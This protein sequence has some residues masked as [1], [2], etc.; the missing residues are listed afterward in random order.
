MRSGLSRTVSQLV[1]RIGVP[2]LLLALGLGTYA[3]WLASRDHT[4][5]AQHRIESLN[6]LAARQQSLQAAR[7]AVQQRIAKLETDL[8]AEQARLRAADRAITARRAHES[9]WRAVWDKMFGAGAEPGT[10]GEQPDQPEKIRADAAARI[11]GLRRARI[12]TTWER[13]GIEIDLARVN[14]EFAAVERDRSKMGHY[15]N[16]AWRRSRWYL[17]AALA[18]WVLVPVWWRRRR[19]R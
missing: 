7:A 4:D 6:S 2:V 1:R 17:V 12:Q 8:A 13:D 3:G 5:F 18:A 16:V 15:L 19:P 10:G 14:R 9:W 11:A